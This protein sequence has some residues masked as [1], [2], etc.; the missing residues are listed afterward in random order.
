MAKK[1]DA[2]KAVAATS[3]DAS[4]FAK[5]LEAEKSYDDSVAADFNAIRR[6]AGYA[7]I[8]D[9]QFRRARAP[10]TTVSRGTG[11]QFRLQYGGG[12]V[13]FARSIAY[14]AMDKWF[15]EFKRD[16]I[17][18]QSI[19]IKAEWGT[20]EGAETVVK[21]VNPSAHKTGAIDPQTKKPVYADPGAKYGPL[22]DYIDGMNRKVNIDAVMRQAIIF[23]QISGLASFFILKDDNGVVLKLIELEPW[24][25]WP[26]MNRDTGEIDHWLYYGIRADISINNDKNILPPENVLHFTHNEILNEHVG[27]SEIEPIGWPLQAR[28][29]LLQ[30]AIQEVAKSLWAPA[31]ILRIDTERQSSAAATVTIQSILD[32]ATLAPGKFIGVNRKV[33]FQ[34]VDISPDL[35]KLIAAKENLDN[36]LIGNFQVP[37]FLLNRE[38][39]VNRATAEIQ[40]LMFINGPITDIQTQHGR[41]LELRW[42]A[43]LVKA[44]LMVEENAKSVGLPAALA[45][46]QEPEVYIE[47]AWNPIA[48]EMIIGPP[49]TGPQSG[50]PEVQQPE[51]T[52]APSPTAPTEGTNPAAA[53]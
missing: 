43:P 10:G 6:T 35:E 28:R 24:A 27:L 15:R 5:G 50:M 22:K 36:E 1:T 3:K 41:Q 46:D 16:S 20:K 31:G 38:H 18:R 9:K 29:F 33:E 8:D 53:T 12:D 11:W 13:T 40:A 45:E 19:Q 34:K 7:P 42:Y 14:D 37:R 39:N 26:R 30:E 52:T 47:H 49:P 4:E 23:T 32:N 51:P 44:W 48:L 17:V 2:D 25:M 21:W